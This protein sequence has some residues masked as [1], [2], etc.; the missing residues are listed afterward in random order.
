MF[1]NELVKYVYEKSKP[2]L[3][4][5]DGFPRMVFTKN[6]RAVFVSAFNEEKNLI[7]V[8]YALCNKK[9]EF[10]KKRG[11]E[12]ARGRCN[13]IINRE[14]VPNSIRDLFHA[15]VETEKNYWTEKHKGAGVWN[16]KN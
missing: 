5:R 11:L 3:A 15:F 4:Y 13:S 7:K 14:N 16:Y 9:D 8:G 6:K 2:K 12:I 10:N 1:K